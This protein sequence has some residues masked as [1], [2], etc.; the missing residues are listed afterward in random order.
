MYKFHL[1]NSGSHIGYSKIKN[2]KIKSTHPT[3]YF[4]EFE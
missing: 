1:L 4:P 2:K 3:Q